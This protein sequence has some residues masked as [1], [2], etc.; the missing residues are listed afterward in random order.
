MKSIGLYLLLI[1]S[2]FLLGKCYN[3]HS[4]LIIQKDS[5][6]STVKGKKAAID[7]YLEAHTKSVIVLVKVPG[8]KNL[9]FVKNEHWPD[10]VEYTYDIYKN[11]IGKIIFI[12]QTPYSES[13]DW[14]I[15]YKHYF[16][17][18]GNTCAFSKEESIFNDSVKGGVAREILLNYYDEKFKI[19]NNSNILTDE[20]FHPIKGN[21][22]AYEFPEYEYRVYKNVSQ[23]LSAY[24]VRLAN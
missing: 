9:V 7:K 8:K 20:D 2:L 22:K 10:N 4:K 3:D 1:F 6:L 16:D 17:E 21:I 12:A 5:T 13:G 24:H 23:C 19:I 14:N 18:H 15:I 11:P